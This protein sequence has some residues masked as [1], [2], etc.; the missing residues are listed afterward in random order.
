[1]DD[2]IFLQKNYIDIVVFDRIFLY[3]SDYFLENLELCFDT[4]VILKSKHI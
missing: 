3:R 1:M 4:L 2:T